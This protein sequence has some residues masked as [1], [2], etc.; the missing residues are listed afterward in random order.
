MLI[1]RATLLIVLG[2]SLGTIT[3]FALLEKYGVEE[4][5]KE[6]PPSDESLLFLDIATFGTIQSLEATSVVVRV[7]SKD[8]EEIPV[9]FTIDAHT[10]VVITRYTTAQ[11]Q[12]PGAF[13]TIET[14]TRD[15]LR[16]GQFV[17]VRYKSRES[18]ILATEIMI[19]Q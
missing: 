12:T 4:I 18:D 1:F 15:T 19:V 11:N 9:R 13:T 2:I 7:A 16:E 10:A 6:E 8:K 14:G 3:G 17:H 5:Y